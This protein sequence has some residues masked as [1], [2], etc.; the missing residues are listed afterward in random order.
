MRFSFK[1][2]SVS[3][4]NDNNKIFLIKF[5]ETRS[6]YIVIW[7]VVLDRSVVLTDNNFNFDFWH[8]KNIG[9]EKL[10]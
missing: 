7:F 9:K 10:K 5:V 8:S 6:L 4:N 3:N 1:S 2:S